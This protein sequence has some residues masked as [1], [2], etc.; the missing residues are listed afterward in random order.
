VIDPKKGAIALCSHGRKGLITS[1]TADKDGVWHGLHLGPEHVGKPWQSKNP[2][3]LQQTF[4]RT[5]KSLMLMLE[6]A[7]AM[8]RPGKAK[9]TNG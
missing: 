1:E 9:T 3:V 6:R 8:R 5:Y 4:P 7:Q 2:M